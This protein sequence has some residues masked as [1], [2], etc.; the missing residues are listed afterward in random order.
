MVV[1]GAVRLTSCLITVQP[2]PSKSW[3]NCVICAYNADHLHENVMWLA[4]RFPY[5]RHFVWNN[6]D[7]DGNRAEKNPDC[8]GRHYEWQ[9]S[10]ELAILSDVEA[11]LFT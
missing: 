4:D 2:S 5:L 7:P 6:M 3:I 8:I 9:V 10:L 1:T 11:A